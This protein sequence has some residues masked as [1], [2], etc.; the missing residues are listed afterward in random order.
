MARNP[1]PTIRRWQL[2]EELRDLREQAGVTARDAANEIEVTTG[3]LSKIEGGRQAIKVPYV[4]LLALKY[5]AAEDRRQRLL[6]LAEEAAQPG[7][8]VTYGRLVPDWFKLYLSY[9]SEASQIRTYTSELVDGLL[10]TEDYVRALLRINRPTI[11]DAELDQQVRLRLERQKILTS[12]D[13]PH[14]HVV[15]NEAVLR[16]PV[17]GRDVMRSQ[18]R[19]INELLDL[20]NVEAQVLMFDAGEHPAM[21]SPFTML[22]FD[23]EPRMNT[24]YLENGR[25]SLYLEKKPDL[26]LYGGKFTTLTKMALSAKATRKEIARVAANL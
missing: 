17:G 10:Q 7:W 9:E 25:G 21:T 5:G 6:A 13:P 3:T 18:L 4:K 11:T 2:G 12:A 19:R 20:P 24:V 15:F 23:A 14:F 8:W 26:D 22:G 16:R 1:G